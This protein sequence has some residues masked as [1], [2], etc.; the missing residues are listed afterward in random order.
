VGAYF[1]REFEGEK[2]QLKRR[3][4][5]DCVCRGPRG[6]R[7]PRGFRYHFENDEL[8]RA[9]FAPAD[10]AVAP[11]GA[12]RPDIARPGGCAL[13]IMSMAVN[14]RMALLAGYGAITQ[15][16]QAELEPRTRLAGKPAALL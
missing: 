9:L 13:S 12:P 5:F 10:Y 14:H 11:G 8:S 1:L 7:F 3:L 2:I 15:R 6:G 4:W 16:L